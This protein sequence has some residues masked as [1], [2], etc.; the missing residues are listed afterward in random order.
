M[1]RLLLIALLLAG[2]S[3][4]DSQ[5]P[6]ATPTKT[7]TRKQ[8][9]ITVASVEKVH[10][11]AGFEVVTNG[12]KQVVYDGVLVHV[13]GLNSME[14][15]PTSGPSP[16]FVLGSTVA[17]II[18]HPLANMGEAKVLAPLPPA[19]SPDT[20]LTSTPT[21]TEVTLWISPKGVV[22]TRLDAAGME[23]ERQQ[24]L[25][26]GYWSSFSRPSPSAPSRQ[27][28]TV[29]ELE[30]AVQPQT[31][32]SEQCRQEF[33]KECGVML[34]T[35]LG[36]LTCGSCPQP[37][38]CTSENMCCTPKTCADYP[39]TSDAMVPDGC[40]GSIYCNNAP[41]PVITPYRCCDGSCSRDKMCPG[42][43]CDPKD[44]PPAESE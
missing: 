21:G 16:S 13:V 2:C 4:K 32:S 33:G 30:F 41:C 35:R 14:F 5:A 22:A 39:N 15:A 29:R 6:A 34:N 3:S 36:P 24:A 43:A 40:G 25:A 12:Q 28:Q 18:V 44:P 19:T 27:V 10:V 23:R 17:K 31:L 1:T 37:K 20:S 8:S 26:T 42:I 7:T 38:V 11:S 9:V